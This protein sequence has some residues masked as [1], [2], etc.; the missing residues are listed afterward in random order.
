MNGFTLA[1]RSLLGGLAGACGSAAL[2]R[3]FPAWA[4]SVSSGLAPASGTLSGEA[5]ALEVGHSRFTTGG[6]TSHAVM[7]NG[8]LPA[9]L[10]RLREGQNV[11]ITVANRLEEDTSIHWHGLILPFQ[12]DGVPGVSFPG[13]APGTTFTYEFPL[14][15]AGTYWYHSHSGMQEAM[16]QF[17]PMIIDPAGPDP[18]AYDREHVL[19]LSDWSHVHPHR[20]LLRLKQ[21]SGFYNRQKQTVSG[22]LGGK[23]QSLGDRLEWAGMLMDPTDISD[24][25]GATYR[26]LVNGHGID[27]N[28][29]GLFVPGERVRLRIINASAMTNFNFRI[30]RLAMSVVQQDGQN[31]KP[32]EVDEFQIAVAETYDVIVEPKTEEAFG[33]IA[34]SIDRSGQVR[35]T[36]APRAGMVGALP[37]LRTRPLLAMK[38]MGMDHAMP[39]VLDLSAPE[40]KMSMNMRDGSAAPQ[41]KLNPGVATIS[42]MPANRVADLPTGLEDT[43]HRVLRY[44]DLKALVPASDQRAPTRSI[45]MHLTAN[46]ERYMWSIDGEKMS[47]R[48]EPLAFRHM[49]R[50]RINLINDTM[51]PHPIHIHGHFFHLVNGNPGEQPLK[52][53]VNVLPGGKIA[54]DMTADA[55]GD[56]AMHCH[57]MFHMHLGMFRIIKTRHGE[58]AG[59]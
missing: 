2:A 53:T 40:T 51:M 17:G 50:V 9:P 8:T 49:E 37:P 4:Q 35:A 48:T 46:M 23:N 26:Y 41:V 28:W 20:Q 52:H 14:R 55:L 10:I 59:H 36:L 58:G 6:K 43:G 32:V 33:M 42:P 1:R 3:L 39:A 45:D 12:M 25:T 44:S 34:E 13:I 19:L 38:D 31:V 11:R 22:L 16:G 24:V 27:E 7:I 29:T 30:P 56:W 15:Q 21:A 5:I 18:V 47:E 54:L 57:M